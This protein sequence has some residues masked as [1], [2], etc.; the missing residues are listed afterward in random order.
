MT[1]A[2][3]PVCNSQFTQKVYPEFSGTCI[4]SDME[5]LP[6]ARIDNRICEACGLIFNAAGTRGV[7]REFYR[8]SY[9]LMIKNSE[10]AIQSFHGSQPMSQA[11]RTFELL[12]KFRELP[13]SG[14][15]LEAGAGKGAFLSLFAAEYP[16]WKMHAFEPSQS[17]DNLADALP[18]VDTKHCDYFDFDLYGEK[19]DIVV[20]LGVLEHVENPLHM[21]VWANDQLKDGGC[22]YVR[23]PNFKKNPNDLFCADHLSKITVPTIRVLAKAAGFG[24]EVIEEAGVPVFALLV[25][26]SAPSGKLNNAYN[27][28]LPIAESNVEVAKGI[29]ESIFAC[30]NAAISRGE[31]FAIFGLASAG[32]FAPFIGEFDPDEIAAYIDENKTIW[33][34]KVH[35]RPVGG[36]DLVECHGIRHI[37][38]SISPIYFDQ[39]KA[40]LAPFKVAIYTA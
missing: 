13:S 1:S 18:Q 3:C 22:F 30:R 8:D 28:N 26:Q 29:V 24:I 12:R 40:K 25:K 5:I 32:L 16:N 9:S 34:S 31:K 37:A 39:V 6:N 27:E 11:E 15:I 21:L 17:Y 10:A 19:A 23:V 35:G 7:T 20:A 38:L 4:T 33:G 14:V 36:L 2:K